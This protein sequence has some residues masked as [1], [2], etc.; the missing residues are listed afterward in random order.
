M[1]M[2]WNKLHPFTVILLVGNFIDSQ[3]LW[4]ANPWPFCD[5]GRTLLGGILDCSSYCSIE[6]YRSRRCPSKY[7]ALTPYSL[8]DIHR[9]ALCIPCLISLLWRK[10]KL[11][12]AKRSIKALAGVIT[13]QFLYLHF[14]KYN[15]GSVNRP[16]LTLYF[17]LILCIIDKL[18]ET[19]LLLKNP[20]KNGCVF[21]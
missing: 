3:G 2:V 13:L 6:P 11:C 16:I 19:G 5:R 14:Y 15:G 17:S 18:W 4:F 10:Y 21:I 7:V 9:P 20:G 12:H 8:R 1:Y